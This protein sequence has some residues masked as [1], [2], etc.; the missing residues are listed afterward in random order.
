MQ[1]HALDY[2]FSLQV[3][4][5]QY[6]GISDNEIGSKTLYQT[7]IWQEEIIKQSNLGQFNKGIIYLFL[8]GK[9]RV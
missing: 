8:I 5:G 7:M 2:N 1:P 6:L 3:I 9:Y 4:T